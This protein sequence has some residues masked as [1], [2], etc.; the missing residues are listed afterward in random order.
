MDN[1]FRLILIITLIFIVLMLYQQWQIDYGPK[2]SATLTDTPT[3]TPGTTTPPLSLSAGTASPIL[4]GATAMPEVPGIQT[5]RL[6]PSQTR[7][8]VTTDVFKLEID[9][10]GGDIRRV[11]LPGYPVSIKTPHE[12]VRLMNDELPNLFIAQSGLFDSKSAPT[13]EAIYTPEKLDYYLED[14]ANTLEVKL[15]WT[16]HQGVTVSKIYTFQRGSYT[17]DVKHVLD[18]RSPDTW[19]GRLYAQLQRTQ[20]AEAGQSSFV[21]TYMGAALSSPDKRYEKFAF[22]D[23]VDDKLA[24]GNRQPWKEGWIAMLQ[25]YFLSAWVPDK[26]QP[27]NYYTRLLTQGQRYVIGFSGPAQQ[28]APNS[29]YTFALTLFVGPKIQETLAGIARHLDLTV[30]YGW[31]WFIA[32]PLYWLLERIH[33]LVNNWGLSII[34]LTLLVKLAFFHLS[35]TSYK[36]MAKMRKIHPRL[37]TLKERYG[38]DKARLNQAMMELYR[39]EK[40]NPLGGCLPI[41]VQIPVFIAL[42]W[43]LLESVELRQA[44]FMLWIQDLSI[45]DPFFVLPLIMGATM[46][47]QH[48]LNPSP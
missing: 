45:P 42:Y 10:V 22:T 35:A 3:A 48:Y 39:Q 12:P 13:H 27:Y 5:Q 38:D 24:K 28:V 16:N 11:Y 43:V 2:P 29:Q 8:Q 15:N 4:P 30:D 17:V 33:D 44:H 21:Y 46:F 40:I 9:T 23:I 14:D 1:N 26:E 36:S 47:V 37:V 19:Q 18:N 31:L 34:F 6:L 41:L 32:Q 20:V 7:V 25:H